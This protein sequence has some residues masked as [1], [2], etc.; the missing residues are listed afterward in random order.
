[1]MRAEKAVDR[2]GYRLHRKRTV[3]RVLL[4]AV[5]LCGFATLR[6]FGLEPGKTLVQYVLRTWN[7][8]QGLPQNSIRA[9]LQTRDGL[10]WIGTRG[11]LARFDGASFV[12][13]KAGAPNSIPGEAVTG[14]AEDRDGS[15]WI[16]S[17]GG[18]TRDRDGHFQTYSSRDGLPATS[19]WRIARDPAG[20]VWA[21]TWHSELFHFDGRRVR[22]YTSGIPARPEEVNALLDDS[23]GT[24]WVA[25]FDGLF[26]L[27]REGGFR[28]FTRKDGVAGDRVYALALDRQQQ[29]WAAG[30][31]GL[32]RQTGNRFVSFPIRG[33]PTATLLA[34]DP[35][36]ED[37]AIWTG[38]T[39][40]GVFRVGA[41][42]V[43]RLG[44]AQGLTSAEVYGLYFSRDGSLW[45]G[46]VNGLN[47][48]SD[49]AVTTYSSG[50]GLPPST[51]DLQRA[52]GPGGELWFGAGDRL[53][54]VRDGALVPV[55]AADRRRM[56]RDTP[57]APVA[58]PL[59]VR[60][61]DRGSRGLVFTDSLGRGVLSDGALHR[62]L[63]RIPWGSVG[64]LLIARDGTIWAA[65]SEIGIV[66]YP[67]HGAPRAYTMANGLYDNNVGALAE[68][69]AGDIWAGTLSGLNRIRHGT[70]TRVVSCTRVTS[71]DP[72][73]DGTLWAGSD[74]GLIFVPLAP[75]PV[76]I[77]AQGDGL[78]TGFI[79]GVVQDREGRLW[80]GTQQGIVRIDK[81][82]LL[83]GSR[84]PN[85]SVVF[86]I[87]DGFRSA[88]LRPNSI[89]RSSHGDIW[90]VTLDELAVID[91]RGARPRPLA[92]TL[93]D[94]V[95]IDDKPAVLAPVASLTVPPGRH[96]LRIRYT[97]PEFQ[98]PSRIHFRYRLEGWDKD[99][100][101]GSAIRE[102][103]YTG[104]P[105]GRYTFR[106]AHSDGYGNWSPEESGLPVRVTPH[107][108]QTGWFLTL[109]ALFSAACI[110]QLHRLRVAQVS[111]GI[112]ARL[113]ERLGERTRI[114]REL[115]D[116]LLQ[117][118]LGVSMQMY[119]AS[120]GE[121]APSML[122]HASQRLR[123]I[124]EQSRKA[125]DDLRSPSSA[126]DSLE[127]ALVGAL[128]EMELPAG[129]APQIQSVGSHTSLLPLVQNE[130]ERITREA[131]A[132]AVRHSGA[133]TIRIDIVYQPAHF[134]I[135]ISDNGRGI[136]R[137]M[138]T[139]GGHGHW[140][141]PGMRERAES[142]GG[143]L[144]IL[145][146]IPHGTVVEISLPGAVAYG[147]QPRPGAAATWHFLRFPR[148]A[149]LSLVHP[150]R[151]ARPLP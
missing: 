121:S 11:G 14:L 150:F 68:D 19:I 88:Q 143:Q 133:N 44:A 7:S 74:S 139:S 122:G 1:M 58:T 33:L 13:Y 15:L 103:T 48:L 18:L 17:N 148:R 47:Q 128:Q 111:A 112:H 92:P 71:I 53:F 83:G 20:G 62:A 43:Q 9:M 8:E 86:G 127:A 142:I 61:N 6:A 64:T 56:E 37:G 105:P 55:A 102:A 116:T 96:R 41:R 119:A 69:A 31:G 25:T 51:I 76:R 77:F 89:F 45:L 75:K 84:A 99:W 108:Y 10:L 100:I 40:K 42:G 113:Q 145:P 151:G 97:L 3:R 107:F 67:P 146:H 125:L 72:S 131:V 120:Q 80:L 106:V 149:L 144:R 132:N 27:G 73:A 29:L 49:G 118:M 123:E 16:S 54:E 36:R 104:I 50:E 30:D 2:K 110:S 101:Q 57:H 147:K 117:G 115:H 130:L 35:N 140:G 85:V 114:A 82:A 109:L 22:R 98:I 38:S 52:Q 90:F 129:F 136:D 26:A 66:A 21:V 32:T 138:R 4:L 23:R 46:A 93:V 24:L 59:W 28:H 126:P 12:V 95:D 60:S 79:E 137:D 65:G 70:V 5:L 81:A 141:I 134:F 91:P 78:P 34:F 39:G 63:P 87:G 94:Q 124:A 135:S